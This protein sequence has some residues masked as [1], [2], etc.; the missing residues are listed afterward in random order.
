MLLSDK[1]PAVKFYSNYWNIRRLSTLRVDQKS[2]FQFKSMNIKRKCLELCNEKKI[3][4]KV[5]SKW[6]TLK[7]LNNVLRAK[8]ELEQFNSNVEMPNL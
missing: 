8:V 1:G 4:Y 2:A 6:R 7:S 3:C 5:K